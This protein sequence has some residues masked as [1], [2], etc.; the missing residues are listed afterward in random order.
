MKKMRKITTLLLAL[1]CLLMMSQ[2]AFAQDKTAQGG[3]FVFNGNDIVWQNGSGS[4]SEAL[5]DLEPGDTIKIEV[6]YKNESSESTEWYLR[7][8]VLKSLEEAGASGGGYSYKLVNNGVTGNLN[9]FNSEAVGGDDTYEPS[10]IAKGLKSAT[11]ATQEFFY[12][13]TV[14]AGKSG[15]TVLEVGL[16][17]ESQANIYQ[18]KDGKLELQYAVEFTGNGETIYK[19][20]PGKGVKT[21]DYTDILTPVMVG[22]V[23]L[24]LLIL[25]FISA[26]R[27]NR[28][29]GEE[30]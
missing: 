16:D 4:I 23:A 24:L 1:A 25:T 15:K 27:D 19:H 28:K 2:A 21:G 7:N 20:V 30:A 9:I 18:N 14:P 26:K 17:G 29:D 13:D 22:L 12:I 11:N 3:T 6:I 8:E 10:G 5:N